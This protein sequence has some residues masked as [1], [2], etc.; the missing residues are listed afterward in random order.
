M[1][2]L[3]EFISVRVTRLN[4]PWMHIYPTA[5]TRWCCTNVHTTLVHRWFIHFHFCN[6]EELTPFRKRLSYVY[7]RTCKRSVGPLLTLITGF[8]AHVLKGQHFTRVPAWTTLKGTISSAPREIPL[9]QISNQTP[10]VGGSGYLTPLL[11][12]L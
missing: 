3:M 10:V 7:K 9:V 6:L 12:L 1:R 2:L 5:G 4:C 11:Y 8:R